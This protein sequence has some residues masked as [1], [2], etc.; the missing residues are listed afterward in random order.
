MFRALQTALTG[1]IHLTRVL[2]APAG[3]EAALDRYASGGQNYYAA[4][5]Q[6]GSAAQASEAR[7]APQ[8][9]SAGWGKLGFWGG[10]QPAEEPAQD[11]GV[12]YFG[13]SQVRLQLAT[14]RCP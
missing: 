10:S 6:G 14:L 12:L 2:Q 8:G 7:T 5:W 13:P 4:G 11:Q 1:E 9:S 3:N